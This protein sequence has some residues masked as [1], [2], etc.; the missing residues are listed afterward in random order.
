MLHARTIDDGGDDEG[1]Q[2]GIDAAGTAGTDAHVFFVRGVIL[3]S[4]LPLAHLLSQE[5][6][7]KTRQVWCGS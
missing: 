1:Y 7:S 5:A 3:E 6:S 2:E 4:K